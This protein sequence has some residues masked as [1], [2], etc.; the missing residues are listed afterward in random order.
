MF[1]KVQAVSNFIVSVPA[2]ISI[3]DVRLALEKELN[4]KIQKISMVSAA[5]SMFGVQGR[6]MFED[7]TSALAGQPQGE[8]VAS[9]AVTAVTDITAELS[10]VK[11]AAIDAIKK[12]E[13]DAKARANKEA[14]ELARKEAEAIKTLEGIQAKRE[15]AEAKAGKVK[16]KKEK[17]SNE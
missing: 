5:L 10:I 17:K 2:S 12:A 16:P 7:R 1:T 14:Q 9:Y 13:D 11:Q 4:I 8:G 3:T 15:A 6:M